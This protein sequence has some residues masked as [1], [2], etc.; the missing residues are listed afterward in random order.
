MKQNTA[1]LHENMRNYKKFF[2]FYLRNLKK[3]GILNTDG[4]VHL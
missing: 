2:V 1:K 4:E 3:T